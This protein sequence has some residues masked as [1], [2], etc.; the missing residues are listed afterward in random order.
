MRKTVVA[1]LAVIVVVGG[2][3]AA[4]PLAERYA[5]AEIKAD[6]ESDGATKVGAVEVG[7]LDRRIVFN[8]LRV[9]RFGEITIGRWEASG[10]S[11]PLGE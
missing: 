11:W 2:A 4:L 1:A 10:L 7:L 5:A 8:D 3:G 6:M 9:K